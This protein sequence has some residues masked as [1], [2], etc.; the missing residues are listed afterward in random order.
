MKYFFTTMIIL[1]LFFSGCDKEPRQTHKSEKEPENPVIKELNEEDK[2]RL[3]NQRALIEGY[4]PD[5][6]EFREKYQTAPG[7]L[8]FLKG[9]LER[10]VFK[11]EQEYEF[12]CMGVILGDAFVQHLGMSWVIVEDEYGRDPAVR[13]DEPSGHVSDMVVFP[14]TMIL[15]RVERGEEADVFALFNGVATKMEQAQTRGNNP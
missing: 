1:C 3:A 13:L 11:P 9:L 15:K 2:Q 12:E 10:N 7:K 8:I 14:L 6:E 5:N 4:L